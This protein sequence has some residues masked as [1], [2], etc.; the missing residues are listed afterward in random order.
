MGHIG[1]PLFALLVLSLLWPVVA[2]VVWRTTKVRRKTLLVAGIA[3]WA[4]VA[5]GLLGV[6]VSITR[7]M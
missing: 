2:D 6:A 5:A 3:A 4:A 7:G 1:W